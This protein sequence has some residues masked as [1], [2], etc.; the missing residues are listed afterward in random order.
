[1]LLGGGGRGVWGRRLDFRGGSRRRTLKEGVR[2]FGGRRNGR[3]QGRCMVFALH[4]KASR[5]RINTERNG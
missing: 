1:M 3:E 2:G 5:W 4:D